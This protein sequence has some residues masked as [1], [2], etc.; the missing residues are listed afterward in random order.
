[1]LVTIALLFAT[2]LQP[3][4]AVPNLCRLG[5]ERQKVT[6]ADC[7]DARS[8]CVITEQQETTPVT[9]VQVASPDVSIVT[10][11]VAAAM[12]APFP[13]DLR[14]DRIAD[15]MHSSHAPLPRALSCIQLI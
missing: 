4:L 12:T 5:G 6:C 14:V 13:A 2:A 15:L 10:L 9:A 1:M 8:C 3:L 7:C 11:P